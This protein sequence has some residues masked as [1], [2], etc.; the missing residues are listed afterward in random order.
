MS[1]GR[2]VRQHCVEPMHRQ[3]SQQM[4]SL[5]SRHDANGC[6]VLIRDRSQ[7][8]LGDQLWKGV[9]DADIQAGDRLASSLEAFCSSVHGEN[10]LGIAVT[11]CPVSVSDLIFRCGGRVV[12][13]PSSPG[14]S[15]AELKAGNV[16]NFGCMSPPSRATVEIQEVMIVEPIHV[17]LIVLYKLTKLLKYVFV[18]MVDSHIGCISERM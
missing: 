18:E 9:R 6:F 7:Q 4:G 13:Q 11:S 5:P 16:Q 10:L 17:S 14:C 15:I 1:R 12:R 8:K 2:F 3:L